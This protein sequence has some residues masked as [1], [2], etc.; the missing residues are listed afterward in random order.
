MQWRQLSVLIFVGEMRVPEGLV[1]QGEI[2]E[3]WSL[4]STERSEVAK[5]TDWKCTGK[6]TTWV[7]PLEK[8][9]IHASVRSRDKLQRIDKKR[10]K[11]VW[12]SHCKAILRENNSKSIWNPPSS[13]LLALCSWGAGIAGR[14][15][16]SRQRFCT[17]RL[18]TVPVPWRDKVEW[19]TTFYHLLLHHV[20]EPVLEWQCW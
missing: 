9:N 2:S 4:G 16:W 5:W 15:H 12:K 14:T 6:S 8:W 1:Q 19:I 10:N 7:H 20:K 3:H 17:A 18:L 11:H 13:F